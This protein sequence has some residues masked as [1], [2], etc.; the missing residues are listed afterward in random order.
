MFVGKRTRHMRAA[1]YISNI[2]GITATLL[3]SAVTLISMQTAVAASPWIAQSSG[4]PPDSGTVA[5][6]D[7]NGDGIAD[8]I[9]FGHDSTTTPLTAYQNTGT[10]ASPVWTAA[11]AGWSTITLCDTSTNYAPALADLN[12]DG[13]LDLVLGTRLNLCL[14]KNTGTNAAPIWTRADG[15][16]AAGHTAAGDNWETGISSITTSLYGYFSPS[17]GDLDGDGKPDIVLGDYVYHFAFV[18]N[19]GTNTVPAWTK[20]TK[21]VDPPAARSPALADLDGDGVPDLLV[22]SVQ[23]GYLYAYHNTGTATASQWTYAPGWSLFPAGAGATSSSQAG[24]VVADLNGDGKADLVV[25]TPSGTTVYLQSSA[26]MGDPGSASGLGPV[27]GVVTDT[28]DSFSCPGSWQPDPTGPNSSYSRDCGNGWSAYAEDMSNTLFDPTNPIYAGAVGDQNVVTLDNTANGPSAAPATPMGAA[29]MNTAPGNAPRG[30]LWLLKSFPVQPG[31]PIQILRGDLR[32]KY[33]GRG[34]NYALWLFDGKVTSPYGLTDALNNP[35]RTDVL[36]NQNYDSGSSKT[37]AG[38]AVG[39]WCPWQQADLIGNNYVVPTQ[40]YITVAFRVDDTSTAYQPFAEFDNL[41]VS[42]VTTSGSS[43]VP[44]NDIAQLWSSSYQAGGTDNMSSAADIVTD[45]AGDSYVTGTV[46]SGTNY[47]IV[48]VKYDDTGAVVSPWPVIFNGGVNTNHDDE[49]VAMALDATGDIDIIGRGYNGTDN[50]YEVLKYDSS[51]NLL[52]SKTYDN[53]GND[54]VPT[55]LVTDA[56]GNVF[57]TGRSCNAPGACDYATVVFAA[58]DGSPLWSG[59]A[60]YDAGGD[61]EAVGIKLDASGNVYVTGRSFGTSDDIVTIKYDSSGAQQWVTRYDSGTNDRATALAVDGSGNS[62]VTGYSYDSNG[63]S[64]G[65]VVLKYGP[66]GGSPLWQKTYGGGTVQ[67]MPSAMII[68]GSDSVY[69]TGKVGQVANYDMVTLKYQTD[70]TL[71]W[72]QT[73]GNSGLND[74]GTDLALDPG[75][76]LYVLGTLGQVTGN[77]DIVTVKYNSSSGQ[78]GAAITYDGSKVTD[79]PVAIALG[80]DGQGDTSAYVV[81]TSADSATGLNHMQTIRYEKALPDLTMTQVTPP[82]LAPIGGDIDISYTVLNVSDLANKISVE[83]GPSTVAFYLAPASN[84]GDLSVQL[85]T[86]AVP[87]LMP[88][89]SDLESIPLTIPSFT[90]PGSYVLVAVADSDGVVTE[91][92]EANNQFTSVTFNVGSPD[93][94]VSD[95]TPATQS[96]TRG[97]SYTVSTT[98]RNTSSYDSPAGISFRVGIYLSTDSTITTAD[99][100]IGTRTISSLAAGA[101]DTA[102]TT[103]SIPTSISAGSYFLGAIVDDQSAVIETDETNNSAYYHAPGNSVILDTDTDFNPGLSVS[104]TTGIVVVGTGT[105]AA[106]NLDKDT[107][108]NTFTWGSPSP[109]WTAPVQ[110]SITLSSYAFGDLNGDGTI[111]MLAGTNA[112]SASHIYG[113]TN[114]STTTPT[115]T[116]N[117]AWDFVPCHLGGGANPALVDL[118]GDGLLD[119]VVGSGIRMCIYKNTGSASGPVWTLADGSVSGVP[120]WESG[121]PGLDNTV[122]GDFSPAFADLDGDGYPDM[123]VGVYQTGGVSGY[124]FSGIDNNP[125]SPT[126]Q[127]CLSTPCWTAESAWDINNFF[128]NRMQNVTLADLDGDGKIDMLVGTVFGTVAPVKNTCTTCSSGPV[129]TAG[130]APWSPPSPG[131]L[132]AYP[133]LVDLNGDGKLDLIVGTDSSSSAASAH[134]IPYVMVPPYLSSG[135]YYSTVQD[136]G[137]HGGYT[138][139]SYNDVLPTNTTLQVDIRAG[140]STTAGDST[141][142]TW[143]TDVPNGGDIST[144]GIKRYVQY[145]IILGTTAAAN[146]RV[147]PALDNVQ[148]LTNPYAGAS[149]SVSVLEG[150]GSGGGELSPMDLLL[151]SLFAL[152]GL[153]RNRRAS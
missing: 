136:A 100:L 114:S 12:G 32:T 108:P 145:R 54:D 8:V 119:L 153:N 117:T 97:S 102:D 21:N 61:D 6:A 79:T 37:C 44:V 58:A 5:T 149:Q 53:A 57:V 139:L 28:F 116:A 62:F 49:A 143:V 103:V 20:I 85:G 83:T 86:H 67:A 65:I 52:W 101:T 1:G 99:T 46:N 95:V 92:N 50:D 146:G 48:T 17:V 29:L 24:I 60:L 47:D 27:T 141:W 81:G 4:N 150:S 18:K 70:G 130:P 113:Y 98:A 87:D 123:M 112:S 88:G 128:G 107:S 78:A 56:S 110:P 148:A 22:R 71:A 40:S 129:W 25:S 89:Q 35:L 42:N 34:D 111:D 133:Q 144:F 80:V 9:L 84:P 66:G 11:A 77:A 23:T 69:I 7:T 63:G 39:D 72:V 96:M 132:D 33:T 14:Y 124:K 73:Y 94:T 26:G 76:Y 105:A 30:V 138:T 147:T 68:D 122:S 41:A 55:A 93:L 59:A 121:M 10:P 2:R 104:G 38:V 16:G 75:G 13:V 36:A 82:A 134:Y 3:V 51:G 125:A 131:N 45:G 142:T 140:D 126:Y 74:W 109:A 19:T 127:Q 135:T 64:P 137:V 91:A 118:D 43:P 90:T 106:L 115:W 152:Y 31:V 120:N 15:T 151:L